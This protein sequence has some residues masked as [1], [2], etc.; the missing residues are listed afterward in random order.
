MSNPNQPSGYQ[1]TDGRSE[2]SHPPSGSSGVS[3]RETPSEYLERQLER[4]GDMTIL[5][6]AIITPSRDIDESDQGVEHVQ[7]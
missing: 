1:P 2:P 6:V 5:E 7:P 3:R 4:L